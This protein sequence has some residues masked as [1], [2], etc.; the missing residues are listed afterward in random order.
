MG[1]ADRV[2]RIAI[3]IAIVTLYLAGMITG[4]AAILLLIL[5]AVFL[6]T[7]FVGVCPLYRLLHINT[8]RR[9]TTTGNA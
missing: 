4:I 5:A 2:M 3:T 6:V 7:G 9:K 1:M 8:C